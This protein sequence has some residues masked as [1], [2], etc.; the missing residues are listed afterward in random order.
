MISLQRNTRR[1]VYV[2]LFEII[3]I[4]A[5]TI[6]LSELSGG[7]PSHS[8]PIAIAISFIAVAW[9]YLYNSMFEEWEKRRRIQERRFLHRCVH[10]IGFEAGLIICI[11]PL[12]M[13]WYGIGPLDAFIMEVS[14][15]IFFL[16][17]TFVFTWTFDQ[18]FELPQARDWRQTCAEGP[19]GAQG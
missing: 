12:Y 9:N 4:V 14:I 19:P 8:L 17:Y 11:V 6:L 15:L 18:V 3:A 1:I 16:A 7:P 10:A 13:W 2:V 5:S